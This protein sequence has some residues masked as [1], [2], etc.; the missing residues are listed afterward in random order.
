MGLR[1]VWVPPPWL[2]Q[3]ECACDETVFLNTGCYS[4]QVNSSI[5]INGNS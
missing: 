2:Q 1:E 4:F 3:S 5:G